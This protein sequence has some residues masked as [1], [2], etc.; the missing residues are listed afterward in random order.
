MADEPDGPKRPEQVRTSGWAQSQ[1]MPA[2]QRS[3]NE[4][5]KDAQAHAAKQF[6]AA[7]EKGDEKQQ[8]KTDQAQAKEARIRELADKLAPKEK[9]ADRQQERQQDRGQE[10]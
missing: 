8:E 4:Y 5:D 9:S 7:K 1:H 3:A 2:Q 6:Q 10:R